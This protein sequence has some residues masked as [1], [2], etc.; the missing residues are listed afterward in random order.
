MAFREECHH[1][2]TDE[3]VLSHDLFTDG[4][5]DVVGNGGILGYVRLFGDCG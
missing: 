1:D 4:I 5:L 2:V 3:I